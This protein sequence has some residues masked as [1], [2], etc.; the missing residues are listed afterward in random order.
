M[1]QYTTKNSAVGYRKCNFCGEHS[2]IL[3][4]C[5]CSVKVK[6]QG[7]WH[8]VSSVLEV[9]SSQFEIVAQDEPREDSRTYETYVWVAIRPPAL[10]EW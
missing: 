10:L 4:P 7:H 5:A 3:T 2:P 1:K 6:V 8:K 9:L